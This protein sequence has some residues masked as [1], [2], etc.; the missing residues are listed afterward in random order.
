M[1]VVKKMS[2]G[3]TKNPIKSMPKKPVTTSGPKEAARARQ[4][5]NRGLHKATGS[6]L[7]TAI[8]DA[9]IR[10]VQKKSPAARSAMKK[11]TPELQKFKAKATQRDMRDIKRA[12]AA[13]MKTSS[14]SPSPKIRGGVIG[15]TA[16]I[17]SEIGKAVGKAVAKT[18]DQYKK[19]GPQA[20][21]DFSSFTN[22]VQGKP[23]RSEAN[24]ASEIKKK[25]KS[26]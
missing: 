11:S 1:A 15:A 6:A 19:A 16:A 8:N 14:R 23:T 4:S 22:S 7:T 2:K 20:D 5:A 10:K 21:A 26:K 3:K 12:R 24:M 18:V 17:S 25:M 13:D 9:E